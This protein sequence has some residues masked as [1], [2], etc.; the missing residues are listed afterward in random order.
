MDDLIINQKVRIKKGQ[1][2][3]YPVDNGVN[4]IHRVCG[5]LVSEPIKFSANNKIVSLAA[6]IEREPG[7]FGKKKLIITRC[8]VSDDT[9]S[10]MDQ[11]IQKSYG[12][13]Q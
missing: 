1:F 12:D 8:T 5:K 7:L 9:G 2:P 4:Y 10:Q 11:D 3:I 13:I 6:T